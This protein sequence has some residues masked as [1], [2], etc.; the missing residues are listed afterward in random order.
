MVQ[1]I[2]LKQSVSSDSPFAK[3]YLKYIHHARALLHFYKQRSRSDGRKTST[4]KELINIVSVFEKRAPKK[5][6]LLS[7][8]SID[9]GDSITKA[10]SLSPSNDIARMAIASQ[11]FARKP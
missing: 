8:V 6:N 4:L 9:I 1:N 7:G 10:S 11:I 5:L 2:A 3:G